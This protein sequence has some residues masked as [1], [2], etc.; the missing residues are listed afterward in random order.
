MEVQKI[1]KLLDINKKIIPLGGIKLL[2][3]N[4]LKTVRSEGFA[5]MSEIKKKP[6]ISN[7]LF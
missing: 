7:R 2:N 6:A 3:L 1:Y 5:L 4:K